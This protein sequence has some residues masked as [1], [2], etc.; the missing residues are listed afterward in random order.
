MAILNTNEVAAHSDIGRFQLDAHARGLDYAPTLVDLVWIVTHDHEIGDLAA[1]R[2]VVLDRDELAAATFARDAIHRRLA[3]D[4]QRG[5]VAQF[6][7]RKIGHAV[8]EEDDVLERAGG[9]GQFGAQIPNPKSQIPT[10]RSRPAALG[11]GR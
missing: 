7:Y 11:T 3:R 9:H 2:H 6:R 1:R 4:L 5:L 8:A 10:I